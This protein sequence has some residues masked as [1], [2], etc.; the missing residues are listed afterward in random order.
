MRK[1]RK[2]LE[3]WARSAP[4]APA[5]KDAK[6]ALVE[7]SEAEEIAKIIRGMFTEGSLD[8]YPTSDTDP[9]YRLRKLT[10]WKRGGKA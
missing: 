2:A 4:D 3:F 1:T 10:N 7:V 5:G 9:I 6:A 8:P